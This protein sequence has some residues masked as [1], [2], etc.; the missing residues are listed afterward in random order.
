MG[1]AYTK[2]LQNRG[3]ATKQ[4]SHVHALKSIQQNGFI[5]RAEQEHRA[6]QSV[7]PF[8]FYEEATLFLNG[9]YQDGGQPLISE[10]QPGLKKCRP[11]NNGA[12]MRKGFSEG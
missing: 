8:P 4:A 6:F 9:G 2:S 11:G 5:G 3:Q 1:S 7:R 10:P 12:D